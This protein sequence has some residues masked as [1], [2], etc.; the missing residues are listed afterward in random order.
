MNERSAVGKLTVD[1]VSSPPVAIRTEAFVILAIFICLATLYLMSSGRLLE[2]ISTW[3]QGWFN[4][5]DAGIVRYLNRFANRWLWFDVA[6]RDFDRYTILKGGPIVALFWA[7]FSLQSGKAEEILVRRRKI[8]ATV[9]LA[10]FGVVLARVLAVVLPFRE[11]PLR[12]VALHFQAPHTVASWMLYGWS[13]FP[14]DHMV[15]F[16]TLAIGLLMAS[17]LAGGI[18]LLYTTFFIAFPRLYLGFHWPTDILAGAAIAAAL[19]SIVNIAAYRDFLWRVTAKC[20]Q[21]WPALSA[22][23]VFLLSYEVV[24]LFAEPI[25]LA[26]AVLKFHLH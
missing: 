7:A 18:A 23:S 14:S 4:S 3:P 26:R 2:P 20:W 17:R 25:A 12:T 11:R 13:S 8:V 1:E 19:A 15:L 21:R 5:F 22:A 10:L 6:M 16:G 24:N 9:P